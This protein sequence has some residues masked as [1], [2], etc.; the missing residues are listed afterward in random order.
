M[1]THAAATAASTHRHKRTIVCT[2]RASCCALIYQS[3]GTCHLIGSCVSGTYR[4]SKAKYSISPIFSNQPLL[5][6]RD[7][8]GVARKLE[9]TMNLTS[10][11]FGLFYQITNRLYDGVSVIN[12]RFWQDRTWIG[13]V[14]MCGYGSIG[15]AELR[16]PTGAARYKIL[17]AETLNGFRAEVDLLRMEGWIGWARGAESIELIAAVRRGSEMRL[18]FMKSAAVQGELDAFI[19]VLLSEQRRRYDSGVSEGP[20]IDATVAVNG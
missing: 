12:N 2:T 13:D 5:G 9:K 18:H 16:D 8:S 20:I 3:G 11:L 15:V 10:I 6:L 1:K 4:C 7:T 14:R 17:R 19:G